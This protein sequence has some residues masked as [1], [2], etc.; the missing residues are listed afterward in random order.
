LPVEESLIYWQESFKKISEDVFNKQYAYN[1][2]HN[3]GLE[4][5][6]ADYQPYNCMRI[7]TT[8]RPGPGEHHGCP[9]RHFSE[10]NLRQELLRF[11]VPEDDIPQIIQ[12]AAGNHCQAACSKVFKSKELEP[13]Q[14]QGQDIGDIEELIETPN[15][16]FNQAYRLAH[17]NTIT[18]TEDTPGG[19][20][21]VGPTQ[22][23]KRSRPTAYP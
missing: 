5:K 12:L 8:N 3:Y 19:S 16:Y 15:Q 2:R 22:S 9:F 23:R 1:I 13:R 4:G 14:L 20:A 7:I 10:G 6:R 18:N 17:G 21:Y 11:G